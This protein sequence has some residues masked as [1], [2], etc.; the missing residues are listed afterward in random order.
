MVLV[1]LI[2]L[3]SSLLQ[4]QIIDYHYIPTIFFLISCF[5]T[6]LIQHPIFHNFHVVQ[7]NFFFRQIQHLILIIENYDIRFLVVF[8]L[9]YR[10]LLKIYYI[11]SLNCVLYL[12][13]VVLL[14]F[15]LT[16]HQQSK[17]FLLMYKLHLIDLYLKNLS[18][19]WQVLIFQGLNHFQII[20]HLFLNN[21]LFPLILEIY[22]LNFFFALEILFL[23]FL[24]LYIHLL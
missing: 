14:L 24:V 20:L 9:Y 6:L 17:L 15:V 3:K 4:I 21:M 11:H 7:I 16:L 10:L 13:L 2:N 12:I 18:F 8:P 19:L 1:V 23:F 5:Q 22:I